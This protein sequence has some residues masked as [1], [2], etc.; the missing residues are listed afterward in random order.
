M[1]ILILILFLGS[2]FIISGCS[3]EQVNNITDQENSS[4]ISVLTIP[5]NWKYYDCPQKNYCEKIAFPFSANPNGPLDIQQGNVIG[6]YLNSDAYFIINETSNKYSLQESAQ[7]MDSSTYINKCNRKVIYMENL[8][9]YSI[10]KYTTTTQE[11]DPFGGGIY[12]YL[13]KGKNHEFFVRASVKSENDQ[14]LLDQ[15][16]LNLKFVD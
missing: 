12:I 4:Y 3:K 15:T 14:K 9:N 2:T 11:K 13:I 1:Q 5:S 8:P 6:S 10:L 7:C 16:M